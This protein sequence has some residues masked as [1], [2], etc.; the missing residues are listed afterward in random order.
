MSYKFFANTGIQFFGD[1]KELPLNITNEEKSSPTGK[2]TLRFAW[3]LF[4]DEWLPFSIDGERNLL[5]IYIN[6]LKQPVLA[7]DTT[8]RSNAQH[9][10]LA[11]TLSIHS[12]IE[13]DI[14]QKL[15]IHPKY[16]HDQDN[17]FNHIAYNSEIDDYV[18]TIFDRKQNSFT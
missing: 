11:G 9:P 18:K 8:I 14:A 13:N 4:R 10:Q 12:L 7:L 1:L 2:T 6:K 16:N 5:R 17:L 15:D 3:Q